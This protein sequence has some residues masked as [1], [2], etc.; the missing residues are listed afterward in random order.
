MSISHQ[1]WLKMKPL[2]D[3]Y[4]N[5]EWFDEYYPRI[6]QIVDIPKF[7]EE[8]FEQWIHPHHD[9]HH[10]LN[11]YSWID[12]SNIEFELQ[13]W[14]FSELS[15]VNVIDDF[16]DYVNLR[17]RYKSLDQFCCNKKDILHWS[18][19]GTWRTP[20]IILKVND[21]KNGSPEFCELM[22]PYQLIEG[23]S[24]L[25]Y[26]FSMNEMSETDIVKVAAAHKVFLCKKLVM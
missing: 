23:H 5:D 2:K 20:P 24:R 13:D 15:K 9:E 6:K 1:T 8:V 11:N 21:F 7:P 22:A 17:S 14:N 26:L 12:W 18:E 10:T 19:F 16:R 25:G 3:K 4:G